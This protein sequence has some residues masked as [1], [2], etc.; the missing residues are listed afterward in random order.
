MSFLHTLF[1]VGPV[2]IIRIGV[3]NKIN[4]VIKLRIS[5]NLANFAAYCMLAA[6]CLVFGLY[7][8]KV[9]KEQK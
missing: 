9:Y 1:L 3:I 7:I 4:G 6:K 8:N 2:Y 5:N